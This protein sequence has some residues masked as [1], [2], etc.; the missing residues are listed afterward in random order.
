MLAIIITTTIITI[1]TLIP[2]KVLKER[3]KYEMT[4]LNHKQVTERSKK[5]ISFYVLK[6]KHYKLLIP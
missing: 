5:K 6:I 1:I 3:Q 4:Y 2:S